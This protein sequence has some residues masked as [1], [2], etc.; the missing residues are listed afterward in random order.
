VSKQPDFRIWWGLAAAS[1]L[2]GGFMVYSQWNGI[3]EQQANVEK[4]QKQ[5]S[6]SAGVRKELESSQTR[7]GELRTKLAHLERGVPD[8]RYIPTLLKELEQFGNMNGI[9]MIGV[10]PVPIKVAAKPDEKSTQAYQE[11]AIEVKGRGT[12]GDGLRFLRALRTF[13]K[14]VA[15]RTVSL[16]PKVSSSDRVGVG[17]NLEMT[18]ELKVFVF[19]QEKEDV[20]AS[21][22][23]TPAS[24]VALAEVP[25]NG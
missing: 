4:I 24:S 14:I 25:N 12:Y 9:H 8:F 18:V 10:R 5:V 21:K 15:A 2:V 7:L 3:S 20:D 13:P 6:D 23:G 22:P 16:Q 19:P 11:M 17:P 1:V